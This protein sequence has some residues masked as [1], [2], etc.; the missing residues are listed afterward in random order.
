M[1][2][3]KLLR[4]GLLLQKERFIEEVA[5]GDEKSL[6]SSELD[7]AFDFNYVVPSIRSRFDQEFQRFENYKRSH[8]DNL[9]DRQSK[10]EGDQVEKKAWQIGNSGH[11]S[12]MKVAIENSTATED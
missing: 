2:P 9:K 5:D 4:K 7:D 6:F 8:R 10:G 3:R 11:S 1:T 12:I